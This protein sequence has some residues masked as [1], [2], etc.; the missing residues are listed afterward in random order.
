MSAPTITLTEARE[1]ARSW[2]VE[3]TDQDLIAELAMANSYASSA[4]PRP[5]TLNEIHRPIFARSI[6]CGYR[7][8]AD[9]LGYWYVQEGAEQEAED[10]AHVEDGRQLYG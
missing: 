3:R 7:H 2:G 4:A 9:T 10:R 8:P 6:A 5:E 1:V